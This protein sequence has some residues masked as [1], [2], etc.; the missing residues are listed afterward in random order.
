[1][2]V[3][4]HETDGDERL[5]HSKTITIIGYD[6]LAQYLCRYLRQHPVRLLVTGSSADQSAALADGL[7]TQPPAVAIQQADI[8]FL[9][10][11]DEE[12]S[13]IYM[14]QVARGL[15][16]GQMLIFK[17]AYAIAFG[18][19]EPPPFIDVGLLSP[20]SLAPLTQGVPASAIRC[21][22]GIGQDASRT[23][24]EQLLGF[25]KA[26]G[27]LRDGA[28][29][30][31]FEQEAEMNLFVEQAIIPAFHRII[32]TA[33]ELFIRQGYPI[34]GFLTDLYLSGKFTDYMQQATQTGLLGSLATQQ[35]TSQY[36]TL[37]RRERFSEIKLERLL[38]SI[39]TDIRNGNFAK[40]WAKEYAEGHPRLEKLQKHQASLDLW[41][42]EQQTI[43]LFS[44]N[45]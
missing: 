36:G 12:L 11:P 13:D 5:I 43:D 26:V 14:T 17:S 30:V 40:E 8:L 16:K 28:L 22:V 39:L 2:T 41:D 10:V 42:L 33:T 44:D 29:E 20:R 32:M 18:F 9:S 1:M 7:Q 4:Y 19:I 34:E 21:F 15:R 27:M 35:K 23:A 3:L 31:S 38:E 37:T 24:W 25:A 6:V 45:Q